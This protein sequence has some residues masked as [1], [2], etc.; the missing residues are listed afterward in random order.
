MLWLCS[1]ACTGQMSEW[2]ACSYSTVKPKRRAFTIPER[3]KEANPYL[4]GFEFV[5]RE[6]CC[7][8]L[9]VS[10]A[11]ISGLELERLERVGLVSLSQ[12]F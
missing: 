6:V 9:A 3:Q 12:T 4:A 8:M 11:L 5:P 10:R 2:A 1:Y 7:S